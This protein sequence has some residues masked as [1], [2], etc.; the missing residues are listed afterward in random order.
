[1]LRTMF[2]HNGG[3]LPLPRSEVVRVAAVRVLIRTYRGPA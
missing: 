2:H 3:H 1:M